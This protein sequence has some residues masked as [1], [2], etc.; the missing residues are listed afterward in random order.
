MAGEGVGR[1]E[2]TAERGEARVEGVEERDVKADRKADNE[3]DVGGL[4]LIKNN[5]CDD[6]NDEYVTTSIRNRSDDKNDRIQRGSRL[7]ES[8]RE[9]WGRE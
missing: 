3:T 2:S 7:Q 5:K 6:K 4:E 9:G 1:E 8:H